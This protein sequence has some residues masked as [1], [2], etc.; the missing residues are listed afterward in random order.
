MEIKSS[1][2]IQVQISKN[3]KNIDNYAGTVSRGV[4]PDGA[5]RHLST[6]KQTIIILQR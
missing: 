5:E 6:T 3:S 1:I 2:Q 4:N